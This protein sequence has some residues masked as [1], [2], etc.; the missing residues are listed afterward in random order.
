MAV[1]KV[2]GGDR[3]KAEAML[4]DPDQLTVYPEIEQAILAAAALDDEEPDDD[5]EQ[6][7]AQLKSNVTIDDNDDET[8]TTTTAVAT[9]TTLSKTTEAMDVVVDDEEE[10]IRPV[11]PVKEGD[12]REHLTLV[13]IG[14]VDAGKSTLSGNILYLTDNVDKR[15]IERYE[16]EAKERNRDSWFLAFIM[17][18]NEEER[19]KGKTVEV[20]KAHFETEKKRYTILD[21]PGHKNYVPNMIQGASQADIGVLVISARKGEFETGFERGGQTREHAMLAKTLGVA[22]LIVAVNKMDEPTVR[23]DKDRF[24]ECVTK[25]RP[26][27]KSCGFVIKREVKFVPISGLSGAN[28]KDEVSSSECPWWKESYTSGENN[29]TASTLIGLMDTLELTGRDASLPL[30]IPVL[31]RYQDR[32]TIVMGKVESGVIRPGMK[33]VVM[34]TNHEFKVDEVWAN[35]D[36]ISAARPGENVLI[37]LNGAK[38]EDVRKGYVICSRPTCRA[39]DK[40][41]CQIAIADMPENQ[42][43]MTAGFQCMFHAH[44]CEEECTV[45]K[46]FE[47]TNSKG[48]VVKGARFAGIGMRAIVMLELGQTVSLET[49]EEMDFLGRFTLRTEGKTVAIGKVTKL[50]PKKG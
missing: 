26:F 3:V 13:F 49:Y 7:T 23:W 28:V 22:Y 46:I 30:R 41:I 19:A 14:H 8:A 44:T 25:I 27:L 42:K 1:L 24:D 4:A 10:E 48:V 20:G 37:K 47:T 35:E 43:I 21:A 34:P 38:T 39:V 45:V 17:D 32:G 9:T 11:V 16:K 36:P 31:D 29:T 18:T 6:L 5:D 33:V 40:V 15:T 12:P 50:P 2:A